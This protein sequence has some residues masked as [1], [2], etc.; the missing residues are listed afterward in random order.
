MMSRIY[1][2]FPAVLVLFH[3]I[4]L[5]LFLRSDSA[6]DLTWMNLLLCGTLVF[7]TEPMRLKSWLLAVVIV[8]GGFLIELIGTK[9]GYLFGDYA[10]GESLGW[11]LFG[12]SVIIGVNW[13]AIV[14]ASA[15]I[16]RYFKVN[17]F[18]QAIIA[19]LLCVGLDVVIEPVAIKYGFWTW[20]NGDIPLFNYV[21]WFFFSVLFSLLYLKSSPLMNKTAIWLYGIWLLF[22]GIL[23]L[24]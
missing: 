8:L 1:P 7:L 15:N 12:V 22:F 9:T 17:V 10:Y 2:F 24:M 6:S 16:A 11:R 5:F 23:I 4:G 18:L 21:T 3:I 20:E 14:L 13:Y 19:G